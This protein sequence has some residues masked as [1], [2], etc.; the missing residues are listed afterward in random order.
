MLAARA[1]EVGESDP[2]YANRLWQ[3]V[4]RTITDKAVVVPAAHGIES[5]LVSERVGNY[6]TG[7]WLGPL[8]EQMWVR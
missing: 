8:Y 7:A 5:Y 2:G 1:S 3:Q 6:Q 4:Y